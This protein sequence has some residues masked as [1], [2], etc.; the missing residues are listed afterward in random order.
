MR[1]GDLQRG[2]AAC[3][4]A[5]DLAQVRWCWDAAHIGSPALV[6]WPRVRHAA[7]LACRPGSA[8]PDSGG[9][10][11]PAGGVR[12]VMVGLTRVA[13]SGVSRGA[14]PHSRRGPRPRVRGWAAG[15]GPGQGGGPSI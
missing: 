6:G 7:R 11:H 14:P 3:S 13:G 5:W 9:R 8:S 15:V 1:E 2:P 10:P 12:P 4:R